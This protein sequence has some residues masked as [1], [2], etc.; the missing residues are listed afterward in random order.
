MTE[1]SELF[2]KNGQLNRKQA[3]F[4]IQ[5]G[6]SPGGPNEKWVTGNP[7]M[8]WANLLGHDDLSY[9]LSELKKDTAT[10][11]KNGVPE[12]LIQAFLQEAIDER[13]LIVESHRLKD[14]PSL[15]EEALKIVS[16]KT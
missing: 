1:A 13:R 15:E 6:M 9:I 10:A 12:N 11:R 5:N 3:A 4:L 8:L 2:G 7:C 14:L 16:E